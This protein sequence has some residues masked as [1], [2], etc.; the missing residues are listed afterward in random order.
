LGWTGQVTPDLTLGATWESKTKT[1]KFSKYS[2]LFADGG[3]FDIPEN[4]GVG[5][6]YK[7]A[8]VWTFAAD[9][10]EIK[11]GSIPSVANPL[12]NLTALGNLLGSSNGPGFG[13]KDISVVKL[14]VSYDYTPELTL[15]AGYNHTGQPIP[16]DQTFFNILA[17]GIVQ[18]HVSLGGT[19]KTSKT[20]ELSVAYTPAFSSTVNGAGSIPASCGGGNANLTM[21]EDSLG[22][23]YGW[24][25]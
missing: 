11:Y 2:G 24:K 12:S 23:A 1:G 14:G 9:I 16:T 13:W 7:F 21:S 4:Y 20:G 17:P 19:L 5:L 10:S 22:V 6:A 3:S 18:N 8:P 15:R 25:F